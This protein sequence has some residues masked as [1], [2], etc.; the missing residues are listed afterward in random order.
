MRDL[1]FIE[2]QGLRLT[3]RS[4]EHCFVNPEEYP[5]NFKLATHPN[6]ADWIEFTPVPGKYETTEISNNMAIKYIIGMFDIHS[7]FRKESYEIRKV[8]AA[9]YAG[10]KTN[11]AG[12]FPEKTQKFLNCEMPQVNAMIIRYALLSNGIKFSTFVR[13]SIIYHEKTLASDKTTAKQMTEDLELLLKFERELLSDENSKNLKTEL[14]KKVTDEEKRIRDIRPEYMA[15][16]FF[17]KYP[18]VVITSEVIRNEE[19]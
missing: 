17:A 12:I 2:K 9:E 19:V 16:R 13:A 14:W 8:C 11:E 10:F 6:L 5:D 18:Q 7:P 3:Q 4:F 1:P 15:E